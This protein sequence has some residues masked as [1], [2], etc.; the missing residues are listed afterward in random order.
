MKSKLLLCVCFLVGAPAVQAEMIEIVPDIIVE[1]NQVVDVD[2][3]QYNTVII[4]EQEWMA[5]NLRTTRYR[6]RS[7]IITGLSDEDWQIATEG[8]YTIYPHH[9]IDG[10]GSDE[11]VVEAYGKLYNW[12]AVDDER[13]VCPEGWRVPTVDDYHELRG[14]LN[15]EEPHNVGNRLKSR[16]QV[17][18]P[19]G[20]PWRTTQHPR[21]N[22][23]STQYGTDNYGFNG[24]PGG[25]RGVSGYY[26][27]AG[28]HGYWWKSDEHNISNAFYYQFS[29]SSSDDINGNHNKKFGFSIRCIKEDETPTRS[30]KDGSKV[31][32]KIHLKQNYPNPFNPSTRIPYSLTKQEQVYLAVYT[33]TGQMVMTLVNEYQKQGEYHIDFD[34]SGLSSGLYL[35][36]LVTDTHSETRRMMLVR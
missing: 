30:I 19:L 12:Y 6:D 33:I 8:A 3:N 1:E 29:N 18:S 36:R 22:S 2:G 23:H 17:D 16:R 28:A 5:E 20:S 26:S 11:S 21:W 15:E 4:G 14:T 13:G 10:L 9:S 31:P 25:F 32:E 34:A 27:G 24:L 7:E 35:Y